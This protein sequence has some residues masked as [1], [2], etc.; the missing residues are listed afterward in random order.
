MPVNLP[1]NFPAVDILRTEN[2][3]VMGHTRAESQD[4]RPL[5][6]AVVNL[7]PLKIATETDLLRLISNTPLQVEIDFIQMKSHTSK[8]TSDEHM[9]MFYKDFD[10]IRTQNYDGLIITGAPVEKVDFEDVDYWE[11]LCEI[12]DWSRIHVT[13]TIYICWAAF[14]GLY[15]NYGI[16]KHNIDTKI[17]GVYS[18]R[19][20]DPL[21]PIFRGFDDEFYVPHSRFTIFR[22]EEIEADERLSIIADSDKAGVYMVMANGGKEF[23]ITGHS[24]YSPLTLDSEYHRDLDKGM[25]PSVPENYYVDD[26]PQKPVI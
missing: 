20:L 2:I 7:M 12:I 18:H 25:N 21:N 23:Y 15:H 22:R 24:E 4:I 17:S 11:E 8:N 14:A 3:F 13:S 1:N 10:D 16:K 26:D 5:H 19:I 9:K 6:I